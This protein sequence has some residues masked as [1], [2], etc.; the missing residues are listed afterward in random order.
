MQTETYLPEG[1][2]IPVSEGDGLSAPFWNGLREGRLLV[3]RCKSCGTFQWGPEWLCHAC[4]SFDMA[5]QEVAPRG[6][7][8][9]WTRVW[10]PTHTALNQR[11]A[12]LVVV[13]EL[14]DAGRIRMVG[15][16]LGDAQQEVK[17]GAKVRGVFEQHPT[18]DPAYALLQWTVEGA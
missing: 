15:N 17:V 7:I 18:A 5:W 1:L 10:H 13:V 6:E 14:P 8:Y 16:L 4:H 9:S 3:Q 2:P 11:G 12:Y